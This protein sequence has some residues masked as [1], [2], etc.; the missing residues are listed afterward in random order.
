LAKCIVR[1]YMNPYIVIVQDP[2][3]SKISLSIPCA[4]SATALLVQKNLQS[5]FP[6]SKVSMNL[7]KA[8][9]SNQATTKIHQEKIPSWLKHNQSSS[10]S[11]NS[12]EYAELEQELFQDVA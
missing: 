6:Q 4:E 8:C 5:L 9:T 7:S 3:N 1:A 2:K 12:T 10:P 11:G